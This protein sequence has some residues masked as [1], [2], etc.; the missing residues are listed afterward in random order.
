[1]KLKIL[2]LKNG[3]FGMNLRFGFTLIELLVVVLIIGI[4]AAVALPQYRVAVE[5]ACYVQLLA[6]ADA[7]ADAQ[8]VFFLANGAYAQDLNDL[9]ISFPAGGAVSADGKTVTYKRFTIYN[10]YP[11]Y[12]VVSGRTD[13]GPA[14]FNYY[15]GCRQCR[16]SANNA[17]QG[18]ICKALGA[19]FKGNY[20]D[21]SKE[22]YYEW[23]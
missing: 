17:D 2:M 23:D 16:T 14:Y 1:M 7:V 6:A 11:A 4:L 19:V 18:R 10:L 13:T 5:K 22:D 9:D 8:R 21:G 15:T 3:S 12:S 20:T